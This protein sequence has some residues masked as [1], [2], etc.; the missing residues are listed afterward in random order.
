MGT[1]LRDLCL[2][3][4]LLDMCCAGTE[5]GPLSLSMKTGQQLPFSFTTLSSPT[6]ALKWRKTIYSKCGNDWL[7][8]H[9]T[10]KSI[11]L[12]LNTEREYMET[13][14]RKKK[15]K[16]NEGSQSRQT[17]AK[18]IFS[19]VLELDERKDAWRDC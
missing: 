10:K 16:R 5:V 19:I 18:A 1:E 8:H 12:V 14:E 9:T 3:S 2:C 6:V 11:A 17:K 7:Y 13:L 4:S 15:G